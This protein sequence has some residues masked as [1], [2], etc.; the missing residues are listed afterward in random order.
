[1]SFLMLKILSCYIL[2]KPESVPAPVPEGTGLCAQP[3][4]GRVSRFLWDVL[5]LCTSLHL[6]PPRE[7]RRA[8]DSSDCS[9]GASWS[10][11]CCRLNCVPQKKKYV[12]G[13]P[14]VVQQKL[15]QLLFTRMHFPSLASLS[16][17]RV[18]SCCELWCRSQTQLR[19]GVV[20]AVAVA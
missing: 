15:N 13:V 10:T 17:S 20:V 6:L 9:W 1:M 8:A 3:E 7:R 19:S 11:L 2:E 12:C 14:V 5:L 16:G 4:K 18:L